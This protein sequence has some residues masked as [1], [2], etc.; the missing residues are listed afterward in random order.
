MNVYE[1]PTRIQIYDDDWEHVKIASA[2]S[3][4]TP[5]QKMAGDMI[6]ALVTEP[7]G[8]PLANASGPAK[9]RAVWIRLPVAAREVVDEIRRKDPNATWS[10]LLHAAVLKDK[11]RR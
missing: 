8:Q 2:V 11:Q 10:R 4:G 7:L 3:R 1:E 9:R 6:A 5:A